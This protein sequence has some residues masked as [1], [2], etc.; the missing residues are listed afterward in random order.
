MRRP[1][2]NPLTKESRY[3]A[4]PALFVF[5]KDG[6]VT[7]AVRIVPDAFSG[8]A[9]ARKK[10]GRDVVLTPPEG[11]KKGFLNWRE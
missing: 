4:S 7:K 1:L 6:K 9:D 5:L 2:A 8:G 11:G 10:Y 3:T